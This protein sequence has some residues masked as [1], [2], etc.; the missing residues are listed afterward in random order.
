[1]LKT[2]QVQR[3]YKAAV[4][5]LMRL[6]RF[7]TSQADTVQQS[8]LSLVVIERVVLAGAVIPEGEAACLPL[9]ATA[10]FRL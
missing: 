1:M 8:F 5:N 6:E 10:V 4:V 7:V 3:I 2:R 9:E